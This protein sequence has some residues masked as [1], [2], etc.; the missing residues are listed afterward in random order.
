MINITVVGLYASDFSDG[1]T[2]L[3]DSQIVNNEV[4]DGYCDAGAARLISTLK[5]RGIKTPYLHISHAHYDHDNGIYRI[6]NDS[7]F[8]PKG[9]YC[10]DPDSLKGGFTNSEIKSDAEYLRKIINTAKSKGVPVHYVDNGDTI[11]H[12]ELEIKVYRRQP[13]YMGAKSDPHG[14]SY[15]NDGSLCYWFPQLRYLTTGD[16]SLWAAYKYGLRPLIV[17]GGHHGNRMDADEWRKPSQMCPWLYERGCRYYWD[18]DFSTKLTDFLM[19]GREDA[20]NAGMTFIDI[21]GDI[22]MAFAEGKAAI[23]H[24][25]RT[26]TAAV[27]YQGKIVEGSWKKG[28]KGIWYRYPNGSWPT[29]WAYL[30][31]DGKKQWFFFDKDGWMKTG[32]QKLKWSKGE[33]W[34]YFDLKTGAMKTGW[35]KLKWSKGENWFYFDSNGAMQTGWKWLTKDGKAGW[36]YLE[37]SGAMHTGWIF[38]SGYWYYLGSDGRMVTGWVDWKGR[39]CYLEPVSGRNQ[40]H[41]YTSCVDTIGGKTYSF[42][43]D[44]YATEIPAEIVAAATAPAIIKNAGF[45]SGRNCGTRTEKIRYIVIHYTG[46]EGTAANNVNYFNNGNRGASAHYFVDRSGEI[47]EYCDPLMY[48]AWHCGGSLESSHHPLHGICTNS[49]SVGVEIC[50]HYNGSAWEFT[51]AAVSAAIA[52][53]KYLMTKFGVSADHVCRHYDVTGKACP[54]VPGWGAVGGDAEWK[55]FMAAIT[56]Q[57]KALTDNEKFI[58]EI[59]AMAKADMAKRGICAA[60]TVAQAILESGWGKSDLAVKAK[61]IFGMK[62]SLSGN[63]WPG[64]SWDGKSSYNKSTGEYYSGSYTTVK[65][66]FR[67]YK[68]WAES[69]ADHSAYLA[70]AKNGS[71]LR[72]AGLVGC[73]GYRKAAQIIK[74]GEYATS[75]DYVTKICNIVEQYNLTRFNTNYSATTAAK[76]AQTVTPEPAYKVPYLVRVGKGVQ[77]YKAPAGAVAKACPYGVYT[78]IEERNGYGKLKSGAGWLKL[79]DVTKL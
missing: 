68:S 70:G 41:C 57:P 71:A 17:K 23:T 9:L 50:T 33:D 22:D 62:C 15:V 31:K 1:E 26:Y 54:R 39:K 25:S 42:D 5:S 32:W 73:T 6:L 8:S 35:Q 36:Y 16:A 21:H 29:G 18:N 51:T 55:K 47:R 4:I 64:S 58:E 45:R 61:N 75:P 10:Y 53:T 7:Y 3:G 49:N 79:S 48:Y 30:T 11:K 2:R 77:I 28:T 27:P 14:W 38:E 67:V 34:F 13:A 69:V 37:K 52:L 43:A 65:A 56:T 78:I 76:P 59:G 63:T 66:D 44:G 24:G 46:S 20:I 74:N 12:G 60:V 40:G 19:T 72:Y